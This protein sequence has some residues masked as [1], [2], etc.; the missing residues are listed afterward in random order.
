MSDTGFAQEPA[1]PAP[2]QVAPPV[3]PT[4]A[5]APN[6]VAFS[7]TPATAHGGILDYATTAGRKM[8]ANAT[9]KLDDDQFD[10]VADDLYSFL[11]ALKDRAREYG[12]DE[13]GI[14]ILSIPDDPVNPQEFKSLIESHGELDLQTILDFETSYIQGQSRSA[15]DAA[16]LYRCLMASI[17]KE[18]KK[19]IL[20]WEDHYTVNGLGSGN[21]LLKI[22]IRESHLDTNATSASIR[23]R[24]TNLDRYLPTIGH[25]VTKFNNY[26][27]LMVDGLRSRG[28]VTNDLLINLFKGYSACTDKEFIDYIRRKEDSFEEGAMITPDQLM[29]YADEKYKSLLQKGI[30]NAPDANEEKIL[31]L[32]VEI[33]KLKNGKRSQQGKK[34]SEKQST[35]KNSKNKPRWFSRRP[36]ED[37]LKTPK[38]WNGVKWYYC[39]KDTGGKCDGKWRQ[40]KPSQC[41]GKS[42][43]FVDTRKGNDDK[44]TSSKRKFTGERANAQKKR[45]LMLKESIKAASAIVDESDGVSSSDEN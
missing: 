13:P 23:K 3:A 37:E 10:C 33:N 14:G 15:Q 8:Y 31:A 21:L 38:E 19:K 29:K 42:Y 30:W 20:V 40:H 36:G 4:M 25:D 16:Q 1:V 45:S 28:E 2:P 27:K 7:L 35:T 12:W 6:P 32:Q 9:A 43:Q 26:V 24:L 5:V 22:I 39:H 34:K 18:G 11:K 44:N 41:K 17:S